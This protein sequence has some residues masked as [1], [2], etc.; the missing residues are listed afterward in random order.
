MPQG[1][2]GRDKD[3]KI[4]PIQHMGREIHAID[5]KGGEEKYPHRQR[6]NRKRREREIH[7]IKEDI[8]REQRWR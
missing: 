5:G 3:G 7:A 8:D 2:I 6:R 4:N 1:E